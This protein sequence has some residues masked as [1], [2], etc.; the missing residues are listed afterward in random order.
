M[1]Y[2]TADEIPNYWAY[3]QWYTL[4]DRMFAPSDS[5]TLPAHLYLV[6]GWSATCH[7]FDPMQCRSDQKFPG[8]NA[9]DDGTVLGARGRQATTVRLGGYHVAAAQRTA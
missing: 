3:A 9:A 8:F 4:Q 2:H 7:N 6:S 1:G 5:W